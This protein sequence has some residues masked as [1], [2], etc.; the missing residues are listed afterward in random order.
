ME[1]KTP[2]LTEKCGFSEGFCV[3]APSMGVRFPKRHALH[4]SLGRQ[5]MEV[6]TPVLTDKRGLSEGFC[7]AALPVAV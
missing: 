3:A 6:K 7:V 2:V 4:E 5:R 1:V